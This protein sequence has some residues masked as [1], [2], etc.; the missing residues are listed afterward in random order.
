MPVRFLGEGGFGSVWLAKQKSKTSLYLQEQ[1][2]EKEEET[3]N[4]NDV[5]QSSHQNTNE[6][7][8]VAIKVVGHPHNKI[9]SSFQEM[10][11]AGYFHRE[12]SVLQELS[13]PNIVKYLKVIED[14]TPNSSCAPYCIVLEYCHGP[15]VERMIKYGGALGIYL[16]QE[17]SSQLIDAICYLHGRAVIHHDIKPDNISKSFYTLENNVK[18]SFIHSFIELFQT[19][20]DFLNNSLLVSLH[21]KL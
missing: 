21:F 14:T 3:N 13:H 1:S 6:S 9:V 17:V 10:S 19:P 12:I 15:T 8:H 16:A 5:N 7:I 2:E 18:Y 4:G 20:H 11:E